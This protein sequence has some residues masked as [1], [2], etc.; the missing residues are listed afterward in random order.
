[1][2][3][4]DELV[5]DFLAQRRI[6]VAGV[7]RDRSQTANVVFRR[8]Q[9]AGLQVVPINPNAEEVEGVACYPDLRSAP[10]PIDAVMIVT[11]PDVALDVVRECGTLGIKRVWMHRSFGA[12]SVSD[13]A[14]RYGQ[15]HGIG[16]I[17]GGCPLMYCEPVDIA[18][19]CL[20]W[21]VGP[22]AMPAR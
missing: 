3:R 15:E 17:A 20:R 19:R 10:G 13:A 4:P 22:R 16:V 21:F 2:P 8:L 9:G 7:S 18:H 14:V 12:G 1:M 5:R 11:R 6:A